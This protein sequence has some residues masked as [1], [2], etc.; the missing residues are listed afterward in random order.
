METTHDNHYVPCQYLKRW[1][2]EHNRIWTYRTLVSHHKVPLWEERSVKS[3]GFQDDLYTI[4]VN[5]KEYDSVERWFNTEFES[6]AAPVIEKVVT[7]KKLCQEEWDILLRYLA[8]QDLRTPGKIKILLN[9]WQTNIPASI[10]TS[11]CELANYLQNR[12]ALSA[13][14]QRRK[15]Y[16]GSNGLPMSIEVNVNHDKQYIQVNAQLDLGKELYI[17]SLLRGLE[18]TYK[19]LLQHHWVVLH[20]FA[21]KEWPTSDKPVICMD[22]FNHKHYHL[23]SGWGKKH[24]NILFPLDPW[25]L[26]FTE[27]GAKNVQH[28]KKMDYS[29]EWTEFLINVICE[30]AYRSVLALHPLKYMNRRHHRIIDPAQFQKEQQERKAWSK[31]ENRFSSDLHTQFE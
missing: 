14:L 28:I 21:G 1:A 2:N 12:P 10:Q 13:Q 5:G 31:Y 15:M 30:N 3:T 20:P 7:D 17:A 9:Q 11:L 19:I 27:V 26:L 29:S 6:P 8:A 25:H 23:Q 18:H 22:Y 16:H 4:R 24:A